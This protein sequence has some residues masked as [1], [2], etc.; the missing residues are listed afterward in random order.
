MRFLPSIAKTGQALFS[1][2]TPRFWIMHDGFVTLDP[3]NHDVR[4]GKT[5]VNWAKKPSNN[6]IICLTQLIPQ[7]TKLPGIMH[8][9]SDSQASKPIRQISQT[10]TAD[11]L[12]AARTNI[13][14]TKMNLERCLHRPHANRHPTRWWFSLINRQ[15]AISLVRASFPRDA[16]NSHVGGT[17]Q[18]CPSRGVPVSIRPHGALSFFT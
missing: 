10:Q 18:E 16:S 8:S 2:A 15:Q 5:S 12:P 14:F 13:F 17:A 11:S 4:L 6:G 3:R 1:T 7:I 9:C